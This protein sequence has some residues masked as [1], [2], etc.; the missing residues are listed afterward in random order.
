MA[1]QAGAC[2]DLLAVL[3]ARIDERIAG[4][5]ERAAQP[6]LQEMTA[7][8]T[9]SWAR[10]AAAFRRVSQAGRRTLYRPEI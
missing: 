8:A 3:D 1:K 5:L 4:A 10:A 7:T 2:G 9:S 6:Q